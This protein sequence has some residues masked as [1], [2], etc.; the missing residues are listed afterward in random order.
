MHLTSDNITIF[1][2]SISLLL[3]FAKLFGEL[4]NKMGQPAVVGEIIAG[5]ILGPTVFG[6]FMPN[7]FAFL[8]PD[9][10]EVK[11][12][13]DGI[14]NLAVI[15]LLLVSGLEVDLSVIVKERKK[16]FL[17]G[18]MGII[19][20]FALGFIVAYSFPALMGIKDDNM[21]LVFAIFIGTA[22]S[23]SALPVIAKTLM[24][25]GMFKTQ[26]GH[27]IIASAMF[28]DL[29]GWL[30]F[31]VILGMIGA[32]NHGLNFPEIFVTIIFFTI[33]ILLI[34]RKL[35]NLTLPWIQKNLSYPGGVL[36]FILILGFLGAAFTEYI[37]IH[38]IFGA[39]I[40]GIAVGDS[41][42][43]KEQTKEIIQQFITN[44]FAP[45][46]FVSIGLRLNFITN[47]D[48]LI[49]SVVLVLAF[50]GKIIGC[51]FGARLSGMK[52]NESLALGFGMNSRGTMEIILG[53]LAL[54]YGLIHANVFVALVIMA[55]FTSV[56]SAPFMKYFLREEQTL[57]SLLKPG[58]ILFTD[59]ADKNEIIR[60][61]VSSLPND[62]KINKDEVIN[63]V[64]KREEIIPT[65]I[66]NYLAIPHARVNINKPAIAVA[67]NKHGINFEASDN[68]P[69]RII[70][71]LLTPKDKNELQLK[72][73]AEIVEK[74]KEKEKAE[75]ILS[76]Q[77]KDQIIALLKTKAAV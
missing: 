39:F 24:D 13:L 19:I 55:I 22:L 12:A 60:T 66:A 34:V 59:I 67:I 68:L 5:I 64:I 72:L 33:F 50:A 61:L 36:N 76:L 71:L 17:T 29:I 25:L 37:G 27:I 75:K 69:S 47:F 42:H 38:A 73:L 1:L 8:F 70:F 51:S 3:L 58:L 32:S 4:F 28:N 77:D 18:L 44:I 14:V 26:I 54:Q 57:S 30:I 10:N 31:S 35:F 11:V 74:F 63:E 16:A 48:P 15:L 62:F 40:V 23:I 49:V 21:K 2:L 9:H 6:T 52:R 56:S 20:P 41:V 65:G 53:L 43:V 46:F 45:L 7:A